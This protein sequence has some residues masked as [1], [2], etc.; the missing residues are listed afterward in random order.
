VHEDPVPLKDIWI[1][2]NL[3]I[4]K[5]V[6]NTIVAGEKIKPKFP[7]NKIKVTIPKIGISEMVCFTVI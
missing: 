1:K 5:V 4:G 7:A 6:V 3:P 2:L